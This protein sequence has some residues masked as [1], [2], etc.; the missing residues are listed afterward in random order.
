MAPPSADVATSVPSVLGEPIISQDLK[1]KSQFYPT[2]QKYS[3][4]LDEY[5]SF[6][7]TAV[8]GKE[9]PKVQ[10]STLLADDKKIRDLAILGNLDHL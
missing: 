2:A 3:G 10:L 8:I 7:V 6:D 4:T 9:F 1:K 5:E